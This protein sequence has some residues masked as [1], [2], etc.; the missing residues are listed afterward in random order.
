MDHVFLFVRCY[1]L[2]DI[3]L[4]GGKTMTTRLDF[5]LLIIGSIAFVTLA[6]L[7]VTYVDYSQEDKDE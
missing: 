6:C 7:Y 3:N 4:D 1:I 5:I 2:A